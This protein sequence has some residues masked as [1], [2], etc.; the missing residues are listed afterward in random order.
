[1]VCVVFVGVAVTAI[2]QLRVLARGPGRRPLKPLTLLCFRCNHLFVAARI[3]QD[4]R[5]CAR[6]NLD[7]FGTVHPVGEV[8]GF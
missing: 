1:M 2:E 8:S 6:A 7:A 5:D 4:C 3:V